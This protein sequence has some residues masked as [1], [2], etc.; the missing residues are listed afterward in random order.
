MMAG[1][2][3]GDLV[4]LVVATEE[5]AQDLPDVPTV[6][7]LPDLDENQRALAE[8]HAQLGNA[9][10]TIAA[11]PGVEEDC[12]AELEAASETR[13]SRMRCKANEH[14][15]FL[16]GAELAEVYR[17]VME[18]SPEEYVELVK[19]AFAGQ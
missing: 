16:P 5:R 9:G 19:E 4:P 15:A 7:E 8:A 1:I 3:A 10:R 14:V 12:L 2:E 18:D 17:S 13:R 6:L 11:P